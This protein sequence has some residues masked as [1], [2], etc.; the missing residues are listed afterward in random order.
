MC[1]SVCL[2][3]SVCF[4][5]LFVFVIGDVLVGKFLPKFVFVRINVY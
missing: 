3:E 1:V 4:L 2:C 5:L